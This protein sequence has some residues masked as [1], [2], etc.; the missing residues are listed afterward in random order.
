MVRIVCCLLVLIFDVCVG[1]GMVGC[2]DCVWGVVGLV[3]LV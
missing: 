1:F 3:D 2:D